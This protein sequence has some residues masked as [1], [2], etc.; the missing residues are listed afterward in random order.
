MA[1]VCL[2]EL[3]LNENRSF[4]MFEVKRWE[5]GVFPVGVIIV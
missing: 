5:N 2:D 4:L 1:L 3:F